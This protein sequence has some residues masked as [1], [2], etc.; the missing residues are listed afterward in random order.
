MGRAALIVGGPRVGVRPG[1]LVDGEA[2]A[3][4]APG[5]GVGQLLADDVAVG[6]QLAQ[7]RADGGLAV[8]AA[9]DQVGDADLPVVGTAEEVAHEAF[10][11]PGEDRILGEAFV[12]DRVGVVAVLLAADDRG[13][14][15]WRHLRGRVRVLRGRRWVV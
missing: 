14:H 9:L 5:P 3:G 2:G 11:L 7:R 13:G 12:D 4:E 10:G 6:L 15:G 8:G 1:L